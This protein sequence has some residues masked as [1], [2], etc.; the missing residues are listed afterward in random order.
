MVHRPEPFIYPFRHPFPFDPGIPNRQLWAIGMVVV[1]WS[2]TETLGK[3][4]GAD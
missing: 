3:F 1:Q 4:I 2:M